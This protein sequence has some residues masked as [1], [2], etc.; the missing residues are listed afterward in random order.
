[1]KDSVSNRQLYDAIMDVHKKIDEVVDNRV[2]PLE[3]WQSKLMGQIA[4]FGSLAIIGIDLAVQWIRE[5]VKI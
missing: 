2:V 1:M 4:V 3:K 5:K